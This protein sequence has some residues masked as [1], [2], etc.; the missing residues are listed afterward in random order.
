MTTQAQEPDHQQSHGADLPSGIE[1]IIP[2]KVW[3]GSRTAQVLDVRAEPGMADALLAGLKTIEEVAAATKMHA[4]SAMHLVQ[5]LV[6]PGILAEQKP[7]EHSNT[8]FPLCL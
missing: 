5:A 8:P 2:L 1:A 6:S 4:P 7:G 3:S